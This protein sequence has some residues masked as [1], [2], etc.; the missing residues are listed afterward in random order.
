MILTT[1]ADLGRYDRL[2]PLFPLA[3]TWLASGAWRSLADGRHALRGEDAVA[4]LESGTTWDRP[5]RRYESHRRMIDIQVALAGGETMDWHP[6]SLPVE[7]DFQTGGDIRFHASAG[8]AG[9]ALRVEPGLVAI[10]FP[11]DA[12]RPV[13]HLAEGAAPYRKAVLKIAVDAG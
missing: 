5:V 4:I 13:L 2:H 10:F 1:L 7:D 9:T 3:R 8:V 6:A 11:D 12:H